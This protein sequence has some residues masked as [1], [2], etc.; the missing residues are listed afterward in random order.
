M[1]CSAELLRINFES[2]LEKLK[3]AQGIG[4][5]NLRISLENL[6]EAHGIT[7]SNSYKKYNLDIKNHRNK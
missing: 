5:V 6:Y 3:R 7:Q 1:E 4:L 2:W